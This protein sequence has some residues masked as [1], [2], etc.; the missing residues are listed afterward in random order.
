MTRFFFFAW[1][2]GRYL[3]KDRRLMGKGQT[4]RSWVNQISG[5]STYVCMKS[6]QGITRAENCF[7]GVREK[8]FVKIHWG[9][10][11]AIIV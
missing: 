8:D 4:V 10:H 3:K 5:T 11:E 2:E 7:E 6:S 1:K 9:V